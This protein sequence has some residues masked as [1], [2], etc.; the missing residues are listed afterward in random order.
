MNSSIT[1]IKKLLL[2]YHFYKLQVNGGVAEAATAEKLRYIEESVELFDER[3][4]LLL[5]AVYFDKQPMTAAAKTAYISRPTAYRQ[6]EIAVEKM[7]LVYEQ[8]FGS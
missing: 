8:R 2:N 1:E 3:T 5:K 7:A 4:K 6:I